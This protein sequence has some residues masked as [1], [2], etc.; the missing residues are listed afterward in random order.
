[1]KKVAIIAA[2]FC[3]TA[4]VG[5]QVRIH[6]KLAGIFGDSMVIQQGIEAP[7]WG[8]GEPGTAVTVDFA[9]TH[10]EARADKEG[11]WILRMPAQKAGGP[12]DLVVHAGGAVITLHGVLVGEVW[13]ASGQSNMQFALMQT[14]NAREEIAHA[15][16]PE[17]RFFTVRDT[18]GIQPHTDIPPTAWRTCRPDVAGSFSGVAYYFARSLYTHR[19]VPIGIIHASWGASSAEAWTSAETLATLPEF[20]DKIAALDK[21]TAKWNAHAA[22]SMQLE[23]ERAIIART[24]QEGI[25]KGVQLPEYDDTKWRETDYPITMDKLNLPGYWGFIW[26][27]KTVEVPAG[28]SNRTLILSMPVYSDEHII[29]FNGVETGHF[30]RTTSLTDTIPANLVKEGRNTIAIRMRTYYGTGR[31]GHVNATDPAL[32]SP[33]GQVH[34][35]VGGKWRSNGS[36]E[37]KLAGWQDYFNTPTVLYN[38]M[39][40][41]LMPFA[42]KGVIWYQGENNVNHA[43]GYYTLFPALIRDWRRHWGEGNFPFLFVQLAS[44]EK[45]GDM[46]IKMA[47]LREAQ[48]KALRLPNTGMATAVDLGVKDD[49]HPKNK[50]DVGERLSLAARKVAYGE[51]IIS[52]GPAYE[53]MKA[54]AGAIRLR[55][56]SVGGGL[57]AKNPAGETTV[58]KGFRIA[59]DDRKFYPATASIEGDEVVVHADAVQR[60]AAVRY[61]FES[62][63][64]G[65]LYNREGLAAP[66]FRTDDWTVLNN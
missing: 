46:D 8:R 37:P 17:I 27:R 41:P 56:S 60:P 61:C 7:V 38:A 26:F 2:L 12:F 58:L 34:I 52:S 29:Y 65:N 9:G 31:V 22:R 33:D 10:T 5:A 47:L 55:F 42:I 20:R 48:S 63:P 25:R 32:V 53:S 45:P 62:W 1:M 23:K 19:K 35:A 54:T 50:K 36:I 30:E 24:A 14:A 39:I 11:K 51:D 18:T 40:A 66:P 21:D 59:G 16:Y 13:L 57:V 43:L 28:A 64:D 4:T 15:D 6:L 3:V 44:R 49:T